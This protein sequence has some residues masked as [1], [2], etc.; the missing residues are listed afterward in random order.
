MCGWLWTS[1]SIYPFVWSVKDLSWLWYYRNS[2]H[3]P[4]GWFYNYGTGQVE[5][6]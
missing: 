2:G 5:W 3:G 6:R 1:D 4:G